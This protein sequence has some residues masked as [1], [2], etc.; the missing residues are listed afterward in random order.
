MREFDIVMSDG[1]RIPVSLPNAEDDGAVFRW[2]FRGMPYKVYGNRCD[3]L[4]NPDAIAY[5]SI[6]KPA[7]PTR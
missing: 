7:V 6:D 5:V 4:V 3:Y 2:V 1:L